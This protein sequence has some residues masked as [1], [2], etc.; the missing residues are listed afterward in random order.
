M[1]DYL[2]PEEKAAYEHGMRAFLSARPK[3]L[4]V[5]LESPH[6]DPA[7]PFEIALHTA[8]DGTLTTHVL[9]RCGPH[10]S[11][12]ALEAAALASLRD[13]ARAPGAVS[14]ADVRGQVVYH[15]NPATPSSEEWND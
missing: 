14:F 6:T 8:Q 3:T 10:P 9:A 13:W 12:L 7:V 11:T 4:W 2:P 5:E 1:R 15:E